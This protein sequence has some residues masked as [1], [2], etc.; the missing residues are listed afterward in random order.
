MNVTL[1]FGLGQNKS[2]CVVVFRPTYCIFLILP[3]ASWNSNS[4]CGLLLSRRTALST[5]FNS[6]DQNTVF[7]N[8][9]LSQSWSTVIHAGCA[10]FRNPIAL[11]HFVTII[12]GLLCIRY[13][14]SLIIIVDD[15]LIVSYGIRWQNK[16]IKCLIAPSTKVLL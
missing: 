10:R 5:V 6:W 7:K 16:L 12:L 13:I 14:R 11:V 1:S 3:V 15:L 9:T 4:Q 2:V 8:S